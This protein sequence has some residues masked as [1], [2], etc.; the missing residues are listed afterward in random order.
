MKRLSL[1]LIFSIL[2]N[3]SIFGQ[4]P[5]TTSFQGVLSNNDGSIVEDGNYSL[6]FKLYDSSI[7]G[8]LIWEETQSVSTERGI[9]NVILGNV[10]PLDLAFDKQY[11][12]EMKIDGGEALS[13]RIELTSSFY[14]LMSRSVEDSS[15]S[16]SKLQNYSVTTEKLSDG[17]VTQ[18][19]LAGSVSLPPG[20][21]AGGD[22]SGNYPNPTIKENTINSSK[23]SDNSVTTADIQPNVISS[24]NNVT[25]DGGNVDLVGGGNISIVPNDENNTLT[26]S[27]TGIGGGD[28]T[29]VAA[30]EGLS[31]GGSSGDVTMNV[32]EGTGINVTADQIALNTSYTDGRYVNEG[33]AGSVNG[34]MIVDG[35][36][37]NS[38]L[39]N[40]SVNSGKV[41]DNSITKTD[42]STNII[43]S[44]DGVSND[45]G[46]VD[47]VGGS[48][49]TITPDDGANK[50][51]IS[52]S[53][54]GDN[55]GNHAA[56]QNIALWWEWLSGDGDDE[57]III[58]RDG[59]VITSGDVQ[60][61]YI[62]AETSKAWASIAN[63]YVT[64]AAGVFGQH[65]A[66]K[67]YGKLGYEDCGVIGSYGLTGPTG[68]LGRTVDGVQG[69]RNIS[70]GSGVAGINSGSG[71]G[72]Y[73]R[74]TSGYAGRFDGNVY[75]QGSLSKGGGSFKIDHPLDP[76]NK[77]LQHS[78]VE[79]PD[80]MNVYNGNIILNAN[81]EAIV[82]L[83]EWF[84]ALN[85]DFRYQLT[86][87]GGFAEVYIS[88]EISGN[89]F[90]ISGGKAGMKVSWQVTGIRQD[91]WANAN[92]IQV[93][94]DKNEKRGMYIH[95]KENGVSER[96]GINNS[97][98][99]KMN[100]VY[101]TIENDQKTIKERNAN[102]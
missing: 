59:E 69:R 39:A 81:G 93:E 78:F 35:S 71:N 3:L 49:V 64:D 92:R 54:S 99:E 85:R 72:V 38:D 77:Y 5:N 6:T 2:T 52:A 100:E 82:D 56:T 58:Y 20:G 23:I 18:E 57:G 90:K 76:S 47:L 65:K 34:G 40:N 70:G 94:V 91:A 73:G 75:V 9:F 16:T 31:G 14:S 95:P 19:K 53:S 21:V 68:Y 62:K 86:C 36:V 83:P 66:T 51:T 30:G 12:L 13:P 28:I 74:S 44:I 61:G 80:M 7:D 97:H 55:L 43:S 88:E 60:T 8:I 50:I 33:Q 46:N 17:S 84:E 79:S 98:I 25:N 26:I 41:E 29:S 1:L 24:I 102:E 32:G 63:S 4:V 101:E 89:Q 10:N 22:L 67:N 37:T 87:I 42:I 48:N 45:G 15:I 11:W 96:L 27:A